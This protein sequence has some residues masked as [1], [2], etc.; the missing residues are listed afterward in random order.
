MGV[1]RPV[2]VVPWVVMQ[3]LDSLKT[4]G[5]SRVGVAARQ[6]IRY[7]HDCFSSRHPRVRGQTMEEV[8]VTFCVSSA[9]GYVAM[10]TAGPDGGGEHRH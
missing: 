1:G 7:L 5:Q 3:E 8:G 6:A 10:V 4:S 2:L 9:A